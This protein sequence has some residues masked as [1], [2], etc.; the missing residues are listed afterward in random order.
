MTNTLI[1]CLIAIIPG[2]VWLLY[3]LVKD[4]NPEPK[5][6]I[7]KMFLWGMLATIPALFLEKYSTSLMSDISFDEISYLLI[8]FFIVVGIIEELVKYLAFRFGIQKSSEV[9]EPIDI[10]IY[11][12]TVALGFATAENML[13]FYTQNFSVLSESI[14]LATMR[15]LGATLLHALASGILGVFIAFSYYRTKKRALLFIQGL[16]LAIIVH[17]F[18]D[19]FIKFSIIEVGGVISMTPAIILVVVSMITMFIFIREAFKK[20]KQLKSVSK[21]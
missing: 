6:Q 21:I 19:F 12:I 1:Y 4:I 5:L 11:L 20:I 7:M 3:F 17:G 14:I 10:P 16:I 2:I 9:D 13:L 18:F 15:F 8:K